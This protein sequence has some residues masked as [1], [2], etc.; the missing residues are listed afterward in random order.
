MQLK[1]QLATTSFDRLPSRPIGRGPALNRLFS[2]ISE[3][4]H[5][6]VGAQ[7]LVRLLAGPADLEKLQELIQTDPSLVAQ[8]LRRVNSPYYNLDTEVNDL[9][10]AA[11]LLGFREFSNVAFT[12]YLSRMFSSPISFGTFSLSGLWAHSVAVASAAQMISRVCGRADPNEAFMAGLL[13]DI[14]LLLCYKQMRRRFMQVVE[15]IQDRSITSRVEQEL[16][17]FDHA[18]LGAYVARS[19]GLS[20]TIADAIALHHDAENRADKQMHLVYVVAAANYLSSRAGWTSLGVHNAMPLP[21]HAYRTLGLDQV[22][23]F[24]IW[25]ELATTLEKSSALAEL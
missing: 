13:H 24:V 1:M 17:S 9:G 25:K 14:G 7:Q 10:V 15:R 4:S 12:V 2:R 5:L 23:L 22:A 18:H 11:R 16:Y 3:M 21:D 8:I 19:W 20:D 6:P